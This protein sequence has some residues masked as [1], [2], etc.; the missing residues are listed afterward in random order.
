MLNASE[1]AYIQALLALK[2]K[3]YQTAA[4]QFDAAAR[5]FEDNR[6]F[7]LLHET[8]RLLLVVRT[9]RRRLNGSDVIQIQEVFS[10]G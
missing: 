3:D 5:H 7:S 9:E 1:K 2:H 6:E 10:N 4:S 8:T